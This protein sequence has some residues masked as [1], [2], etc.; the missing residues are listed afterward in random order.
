MSIARRPRR[1]GASVI[2]LALMA[3]VLL[4]SPASAGPAPGAARTRQAFVEKAVRN[5]TGVTSALVH[6]RRGASLNEGVAAA[7]RAGAE[8]GTTYD[9][10]KVFVAYGT[11]STFARIAKSSAIE[12]IEANRKLK[13]FTET[14]HRATRGQ[15]VL[16]GGVTMPDG[17]RIDGAGVGVAV[18][19]SGI[20][21]THPDLASR[22]GG[23][24]KIVCSTP[25]PVATSLTGFTQ[26]MGP[27]EVV[28]LEDTDTPSLGGHGTHVAGIVAGTG[29]ASEGRYHGAAPGA[30]LYGVSVGTVI[31]VENGLDGLNWVLENHDQ[32]TPAIKVVNN[33]WGGD[34]SK[35]DPQNA[36]FHKALWKLQDD[37]IADGVSVV[38][39]NGNAAGNGSASTTAAECVNPTP[40]LICVANYND[41]NSGT[42][43]GSISSNSSRGKLD[44]PLEWPDISAPGTAIMSTCRVTLP[45]CTAGSGSISNENNYRNMSGTSMAA[46]HV[47]GIVAQLY[48]A[49]PGLTPAEVENIL[50]DTAY[51][52]EF[53]QAY[54][55]YSDPTNPDNTS[56]HEK[57][58]GLVDVVAALQAVLGG[59]GPTDSDGDGVADGSDNCPSTPNAGQEDADGDGI[60]DACDESDPD[61]DPT[62]SAR[63]YFHSGTTLNAADKPLGEAGF[64]TDEPTF[65]DPALATDIPAV[66]N[67]GPAAVYDPAW[68][69][70]ITGKINELTVDFWAKVPEEEAQTG[71]VTWRVSVWNGATEIVLPN[72]IAPGFDPTEPIH[73]T[74][75]FSTMLTDPANQAS[76]VPLAIT[77]AG[78]MGLQIRPV[79]TANSLGATIFYDS[80]DYP[81]GFSV[82]STT[83]ADGDGV[84]D[85]TDNCPNVANPGQE[86]SDGDGIGDACDTGTTDADGDGVADGTDNCPNVAN[87][88]Q[89]DSDGDGLG[90]AC[91][92]PDPTGGRGVYP[93]NPND[94]FFPEDPDLPQLLGG[95]WGMRRIGAPQ[96]WQETQ[97]TGY[98]IKVAVLDTGL[99][100]G[101]PDLDCPGKV[102]VIADNDFI[103]DGNGPEDGHGHGTHVAGIVGACTNN[104][105][106]VVG[107]APDSTIMP[108]QVLDAA[109]QGDITQ[110]LPGAIRAATDA[111]AHV[112]NMSLGTLEVNTPVDVLF[113]EV[114]PEVE[115]A[116]DYAIGKGVVVVVAAGNASFPM[117]S[118]PAI[119]EDVVCVGSSDSHDLNSYF[120][121][122]PFNDDDEDITGAGLMA[123]GGG[124]AVFCDQH[125]ENIL[126]TV[127][128][129][130]DT[131][132]EG[133]AG[134]R[135]MNG[136]SMAAPHVAGV[137]ALVYDRLAGIRT[138]TNGRAVVEALINSTVEMYA[139][140]WDPLSG[141]GRLDAVAAVLA[142]E[143]V[144]VEQALTTTLAF[145]ESSAQQ[146]QFGDSASFSASLNDEMGVPIEGAELVFE[147]TGDAG[148]AQW[149]ATTGPDGTATADKRPDGSVGA[150]SL[151]VRYAGEEGVFEPSSTQSG[152]VIDQEETIT[153]LEVAGK[154]NRRQLTASLGEDDG[155]LADRMVVFYADGAEIAHGTTDEDG[156]LSID[157]PQGYR[158]DHFLFEARYDGEENFAGSSASY[159]T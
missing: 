39:A 12:A 45:V 76:Q 35:Y 97:A 94:P 43:D 148:S 37:L 70:A 134:Y 16:D 119:V 125:A 109:G 117:C 123:P 61:P 124:A 99:D 60:G 89:E 28:P 159:Q 8:V 6:V 122:F 133:M 84:A 29:A 54:G 58:H 118:Y 15:G 36:P 93:A 20:D 95:Q 30:T 62:G 26:C 51:K 4:V 88:G 153:T 98:G 142:V 105:V 146:V 72:F 91:D 78:E 154:G 13:M 32:V 40:G 23:N 138:G 46:P 79:F 11:S 80:V 10:I 68:T 22:M 5:A 49:D 19:D 85:G 90:D 115:D 34:Y 67:G 7:Q 24:V 144:I 33:S 66:G 103:G 110:T 1:L 112:I 126:S 101:H 143:P 48:Q 52:F 120:G 106:G 127:A 86:D 132:D 71:G 102:Q 87:P 27:K 114:F 128:R 74:H 129:T 21:G 145:T 155:P 157:A 38:F 107:V 42:R 136:T 14:S 108:V 131:C 121:N 150:Y 158:G 83:D 139:P 130:K 141:Y 44:V 81:S 50:E 137:A 65:T 135:G 100:L 113:G 47:A 104:D 53:G 75:T 151:T 18:V 31:L 96:A 156:W 9:S 55:L 41:N 77:P 149:T 69:G 111:G 64:N 116:I 56:S 2:A 63:Y 17:A 147:L 3:G 57:G 140:G 152:F 92:S 59:T 82:A 73:V 25:Q